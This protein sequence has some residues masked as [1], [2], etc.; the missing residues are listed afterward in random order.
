MPLFSPT[1]PTPITSQP[2][3]ASQVARNPIYILSAALMLTGCFLISR[4]LDIETGES[5]PLLALIATL[6][7]Y[8]ILLIA[9]AVF[10]IRTNRAPADGRLLLLLELLFLFDPAHLNAE[11]VAINQPLAVAV[12]LPL[13][14][15]LAAKLIIITRT[16]NH[17][18]PALSTARILAV[19]ALIYAL[20]YYIGICIE[21]SYPLKPLPTYLAYLTP[22]AAL[23]LLT[24]RR[25]LSPTPIGS[26][27][28]PL[29][30]ITLFTHIAAATWAHNA[31]LSLLFLA[32]SLL[33]A[34]FF[35]KP[36]LTHHMTEQSI[37]ALQTITPALA[38]AL[39]A[40]FP[41]ELSIPLFTDPQ[42]ALFI[43]PLRFIL[44]AAAVSYTTLAAQHHRAILLSPAATAL[45][46]IPLGH[47]PSTIAN[48]IEQMLEKLADFATR[49]LPTTP[50]GW[51]I[52]C[53]ITAFILI[54]AGT[55][56][57]LKHPTITHREHTDT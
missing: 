43:S 30:L 11:L 50:I 5:A 8:E 25:I 13:F 27:L 55:L 44:L 36:A 18:L 15:L 47:N 48:T 24:D 54:L 22:A 21:S 57:S 53:I 52:L 40:S 10:L 41:S 38:V 4:A 51:G 6:Q 9:I 23:I 46:I 3:P 56:R 17:K 2:Q 49:L 31:P 42:P 37:H 26:I 7:A 33:A 16:L 29:L 32:P 19:A 1:T 34:T 20:P 35:I 39:S 45:A 14:C 28:A 12:Q